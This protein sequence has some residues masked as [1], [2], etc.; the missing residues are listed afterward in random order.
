MASARRRVSTGVSGGRT[1]V[2]LAVHRGVSGKGREPD[3]GPTLPTPRTQRGLGSKQAV[4]GSMGRLVQRSHCLSET[5]SQGS[6]GFPPLLITPSFV[7]AVCP[8]SL[9]SLAL[10]CWETF[11]DQ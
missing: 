7:Q 9:V 8:L 6:T 10:T 5:P 2:L 1:A 11:L 3:R 4:P